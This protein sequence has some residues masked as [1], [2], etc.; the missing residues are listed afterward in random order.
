MTSATELVRRRFGV[1]GD[2][3]LS[4]INLIFT[5]DSVVFSA[6]GV[7][8]LSNVETGTKCAASLGEAHFVL[9]ASDYVVCFNRMGASKVEAK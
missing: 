3:G 8:D 7:V 6:R 5:G 9:G 4:G 1:G 2:V